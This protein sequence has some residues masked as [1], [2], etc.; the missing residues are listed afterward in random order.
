VQ[1]LLDRLGPDASVLLVGVATGRGVTTANVIEKAL[2]D[3]RRAVALCYEQPAAAPIPGVPVV[4]ADA[5]ALPFADGSFDYVVSN[6]VVEHLGGVEGARRLLAESARVSR[7]GY[8]HTTPNRWFPV[9]THTLLPLL[10]W[11]PRRWQ[12][13][14]FA[15]FGYRFPPSGYWLFSPRTLAAVHPGTAVV[16][17][18]RSPMAMTLLVTG[19]DDGREAG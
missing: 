5:R 3:G 10:H 9:E 19:P 7:R 13:R 4:R 15:R 6:A 12:T 18:G 8:V 17:L 14:V 1:Y 2:A 16:R 11:G